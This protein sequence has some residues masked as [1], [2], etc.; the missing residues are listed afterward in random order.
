MPPRAPWGGA[1]EELNEPMPRITFIESTG[2]RKEVEAT[3]GESVMRAAIDNGVDG[4]AAE[5]GGCLSC[6]TCHAYVGEEWVDR[7][8][9]PT[10]EEQ[11]MVECAIDVRP[12]S[13]L[14]CQIQVTDALDGLVV[15][16]PASQY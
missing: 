2:E 5:C 15:E 7:L 4:I 13:R 16:I 6:A 11:V 8:T 14:T 10:E 1:G 12:N 9:P 3:V